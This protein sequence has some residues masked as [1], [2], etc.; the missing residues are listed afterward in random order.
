M[1]LEGTIAMSQRDCFV[2]FITALK[3]HDIGYF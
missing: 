2:R 1:V 3:Q